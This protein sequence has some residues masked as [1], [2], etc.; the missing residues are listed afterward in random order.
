MSYKSSTIKS[1]WKKTKWLLEE[2]HLRPYV[3]ATMPFSQGNLASMLSSYSTVFFKPTNGSGGSRIIRIKRQGHGYQMQ[4]NA[5]KTTYKTQEQL[6]KEL[7]RF[8]GKTDFLLQKGIT[9]AKSNG[10][11]FD[12]RV[13]IQKTNKGSWAS[14]GLFTKIG[15][16]NKIATNY[17]QGGSIGYFHK[18][19]AG[20]GYDNQ[21]IQRMESQLKQL[22]I[23]VGQS[24]DRHHKGFKELGL[25][26]ALDKHRKPWILEV[27]TR[28]QFYPVKNLK[29]KSL[30]H[31]ILSYAR[32]Y[33]RTK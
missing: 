29:D 2:S 23:S 17:N 32:Q 3:P 21:A 28:P 15:K 16:P 7:K 25:D 33:G 1:K 27:N 6:Y 8:A 24:F 10:R 26:V 31:R 4:Y 14:P 30:Y 11:P 22:G 5:A 18:T 12:I 13:M 20:A 19:L 9:L